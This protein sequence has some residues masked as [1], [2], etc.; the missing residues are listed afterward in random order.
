MSLSR[1][2]AALGCVSFYQSYLEDWRS[3]KSTSSVCSK[4]AGGVKAPSSIGRYFPQGSVEP[5]PQRDFRLELL[6]VVRHSI[7]TL[8]PEDYVFLAAAAQPG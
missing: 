7:P 4:L 6:Q 5:G 3:T 1:P 2:A 8:S